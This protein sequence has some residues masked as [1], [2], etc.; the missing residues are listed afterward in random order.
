MQLINQNTQDALSKP[1][2]Y[3]SASYVLVRFDKNLALQ[4]NY[5]FKNSAL[6]AAMASHLRLIALKLEESISNE[7]THQQFQTQLI[8]D[9][10]IVPLA[11]S[12]PRPYCAALVAS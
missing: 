4:I 6:K 11:S 3:A 7:A 2:E 8:A 10:K 9:S 1:L 12:P 5:S